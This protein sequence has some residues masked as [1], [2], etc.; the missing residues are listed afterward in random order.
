MLQLDL[1]SKTA[2]PEA[3]AET[4]NRTADASTKLQIRNVKSR[5]IVRTQFTIRSMTSGRARPYQALNKA[6]GNNIN[7]MFSRTG[8]YSPYLWM[9]E[10][11][12]KRSIS[13]GPVPI[14][15]VNIRT[16]KNLNK[17][18][19]RAYRLNASDALTRGDFG[20]WGKKFIG[21]PKGRSAF[22]IYERRNN[23]KKLMML[24][25]LEHNEVK[26][27]DSN[28]HDDAIKRFGTAQFIEAQFNKI[29]NQKLRRYQ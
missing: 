3:M 23:N 27:P 25:N 18:I 7:K 28:F 20:E 26:I 24:R 19:R 4:L 8:T 13:G 5:L 6:T 22:G 29:A 15:T 11:H 10:G 9:Q 12:T 14:A 21:K 16:G 17:S 1:I 2:L